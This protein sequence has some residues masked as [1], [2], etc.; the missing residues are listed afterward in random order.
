MHRVDKTKRNITKK[1]QKQQ[2]KQESLV[3]IEFTRLLVQS[4]G[5]EPSRAQC[6]LDP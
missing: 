6:S 2:Q 3:N 4:K 1:Q 5:L